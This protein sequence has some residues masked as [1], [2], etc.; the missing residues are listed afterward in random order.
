MKIEV[1]EVI[2]RPPEVVFEFIAV[3]HVRNHP[4]WDLHMHLEQVT[5]GPIRVGTVIRRRHTRAGTPVEGSMECIEFDPPRA[6]AF[7]IQDGPVEM[8]GRQSIQPEGEG[9]SRLTITVDIPGM[10]NPMDPMP[11]ATSARRIRELI[12]SET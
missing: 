3:N 4:R 5:D 12:E 2:D 7:H 9:R 1:S 10:P 6:I 11:V 8:L